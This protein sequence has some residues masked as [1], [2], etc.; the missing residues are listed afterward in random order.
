MQQRSV[1][2]ANG[3]PHANGSPR[4]VPTPKPRVAPAAP[5]AGSRVRWMSLALGVWLVV[6]SF[7]WTRSAFSRVDT[8]VSGLIIALACA[9]A[10]RAPIARYVTGTVAIWLYVSTVAVRHTSGATLANDALVAVAV[11]ALSLVQHGD[12]LRG[13]AQRRRSC[14]TR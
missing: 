9:P 10:M 12:Q 5:H 2:A 7:F 1:T 11:L 14:S 13:R 6:S 3:T 4:P 8:L